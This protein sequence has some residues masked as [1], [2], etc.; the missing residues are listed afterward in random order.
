MLSP[1]KTSKRPATVDF[2][3]DFFSWESSS[4]EE[5]LLQGEVMQ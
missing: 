2:D 5:V 4:E 3:F 1:W